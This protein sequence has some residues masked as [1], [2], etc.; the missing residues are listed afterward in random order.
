[1]Q[2]LLDGCRCKVISLARRQNAILSVSRDSIR[3]HKE[4]EKPRRIKLN[5]V[6]AIL[7][8][9]LAMQPTAE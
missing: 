4:G 1:M 6:G 3:I 2:L 7:I 5:S 9:N 8:K